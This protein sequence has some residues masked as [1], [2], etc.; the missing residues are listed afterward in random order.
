MPARTPRFPK[1]PAPRPRPSGAETLLG[2]VL[3]SNWLDAKPREMALSTEELARRLGF[4]RS[5]L[6]SA[7]GKCAVCVQQRERVA[8]YL[9]HTRRRTTGKHSFKVCLGCRHQKVWSEPV[10]DQVFQV[11]FL[12]ENEPKFFCLCDD[13]FGDTVRGDE[14][15]I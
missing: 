5:P 9:C 11:S 12:G 1:A 13:V 3:Q 15:R 2:M 6:M 4:F 10:A 8:T 14:E 7:P